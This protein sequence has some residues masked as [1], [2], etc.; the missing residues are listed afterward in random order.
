[1]IQAKGAVVSDASKTAAG[2]PVRDTTKTPAP[3]PTSQPVATV[4][5]SGVRTHTIRWVDENTPNSTAKPKGVY[6]AEIHLKVGTTP[7]ANENELRQ[8]ATDTRT[9]YTYEFDPADVGKTA[10]YWLRWVNTRGVVG[11]WG[12]MVSATITG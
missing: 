2:I 3:V 11:P 6:G 8:I 1:V 5:V 12:V 7:P 4:S 10:Y 9:P